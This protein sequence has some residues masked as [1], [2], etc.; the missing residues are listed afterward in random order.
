MLQ[1]LVEARLGKRPQKE[2]QL[3]GLVVEEEMTGAGVYD[4]NRPCNNSV[5]KSQRTFSMFP[6]VLKKRIRKGCGMN[7]LS[8]EVKCCV[9][10][11]CPC[12]YL[13]TCHFTC[14]GFHLEKRV[15]VQVA[16]SKRVPGIEL[17]PAGAAGKFSPRQ[18]GLAAFGVVVITVTCSNSLFLVFVLLHFL[19]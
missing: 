11:Y 8:E 5:R 3:L 7:F 10:T 19:V 1:L 6:L 17:L 9:S 12:K 4:V 18:S 14:P 2:F 15:K 16:Q 13:H